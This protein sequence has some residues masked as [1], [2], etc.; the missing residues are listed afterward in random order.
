[1][2]S[3]T[4]KDCDTFFPL[5]P[6]KGST[7][8]QGPV[9]NSVYCWGCKALF[10]ALWRCWQAQGSGSQQLPQTLKTISH[11]ELNGLGKEDPF[12]PSPS[13]TTQTTD[14]SR[15]PISEDLRLYFPLYN[16]DSFQDHFYP[17]ATQ[18]TTSLSSSFL[19]WRTLKMCSFMGSS[20]K[21]RQWCW[22]DM[23]GVLAYFLLVG[24]KTLARDLAKGPFRSKYS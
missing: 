5:L 22:A 15:D 11:R 16:A 2:E 7:G 19:L 14:A 17:G 20:K 10:P 13:Y 12:L 18:S 24:S 4:G 3:S 9:T 21:P 1:M 8:T 23:E 6:K